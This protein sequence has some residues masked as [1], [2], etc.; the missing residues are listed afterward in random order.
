M[1]INASNL[2]NLYRTFS[3]EFNRS[4]AAMQL[5]TNLVALLASVFPSASESTDYGFLG[6]VPKMRE[7]I[8]ERQHSNLAAYHYVLANRDFEATVDVPRNKILDDQYG[9]FTPMIGMLAEA[10]AQHKEEL[11]VECLEAGFTELCFDGQYFFDTDHPAVT[12]AGAATTAANLNSGSATYYWYLLDL[13]KPLKPF[14][15]QVRQ[16]PQLTRKDN[17]NDENV[18]ERKVFSYGVDDRKA[19]GY[20]M[21]QLAYA[22][23]DALDSTS[24]R[25]ARAAM[26][27]L[28]DDQGRPLGITPTH[29]LVHPTDLF[30]AKALFEM[31]TTSAGAA[32]PDFGMVKIIENVRATV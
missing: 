5:K 23:K 13:S 26:M 18:F 3:A 4:M 15:M 12:A 19:C 29:I 10:A 20:G 24:W 16:E 31:P 25:A 8:G 30:A 27:A 1:L 6:G 28:L 32:N 7:W 22:C 21:W 9:V 14:I 2:A 11:L 17:P